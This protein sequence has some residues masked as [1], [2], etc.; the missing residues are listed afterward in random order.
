[1]T[2]QQLYDKISEMRPEQMNSSVKIQDSYDPF[3]F[4]PCMGFSTYDHKD[5][6][7]IKQ[8]EPFLML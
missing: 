3:C 4:Y 7:N 5:C 2:W 1:M 8:N 6:E